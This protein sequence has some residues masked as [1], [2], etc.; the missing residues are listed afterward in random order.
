M[1]WY[2]T[3]SNHY[4]GELR[5][6]GRLLNPNLTM[7]LDRKLGHASI[8][9]I[10]LGRINFTDIGDQHAGGHSKATWGVLISYQGEELV[11][12]YEGDGQIQ[13]DVN[14]FGQAEITGNG[15]F[16]RVPLP[17]FVLK[18]KDEGNNVISSN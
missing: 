8:E 4:H 3:V 17:S 12:R 5:E 6:S 7:K 16:S 10:G 9:V 18:K 15:E 11:F 13:L 14:K 1:A 2:L